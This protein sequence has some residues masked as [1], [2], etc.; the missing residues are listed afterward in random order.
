MLFWV[1]RLTSH[2]PVVNKPSVAR[3]L[4]GHDVHL[5]L[6]GEPVRKDAIGTNRLPHPNCKIKDRGPAR[7]I[8]LSHAN[9]RSL[10]RAHSP[11]NLSK[12]GRINLRHLC[13]TSEV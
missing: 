4:D 5:A 13:L 6:S 2:M 8:V 12:I 11:R 3:H 10:S 7:F 1:D 9:H